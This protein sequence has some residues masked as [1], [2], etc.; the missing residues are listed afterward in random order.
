MSN[1][2]LVD[3]NFSA[4]PI[5]DYLVQSGH[6][7][8]VV[9][10]KPNDALAKSVNNYVNLDYTNIDR[11]L[12][13]VEDHNIDFLVP[14]CNDRSYLVCAELNS[15]GNFPGI[16]KLETAHTINNKEMFRAFC[17]GEGL[18]TPKVLNESEIG[19]KWP[20]IVKPVDAYSGRGVTVIHHEDNERLKG[21]LEL[22]ASV[23]VSGK[24]IVESYVEGQLYSHSAFIKN[25]K[26]VWDQVV[27]EYG[28]VNPF[29]VDTSH[30]IYD[31]PTFY[32]E[33]LCNSVHKICKKLR[34][35]NGLVHTQFIFD[36][37]DLWLIEVTRRCPGDLYSSL[38]Q[39]STGL[40][41][42]ENYARPFLGTDYDF[43]R[44][45]E[46]GLIMRHTVSHCAEYGFTGLSFRRGVLI[47]NL[48]PLCSNGD[49]MAAGPRGRAAII[50]AEERSE[51]DL[52]S[53]IETTLRRDLYTI[54]E[55]GI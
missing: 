49:Q 20:V 32:R 44:I 34:L 22:A 24:Y 28:T 3:T 21:A 14:G 5:Y 40:N 18:P 55:T 39:Y 1:V 30:V 38:I 50:F 10:A 23:S 51:S 11:M 12:R 8:T 17:A 52:N 7:V 6:E 37:N 53:L 46:G 31:F 9:G 29:A 13:L 15:H 45:D 36:G 33:Q 47:R 35:R 16:D 43:N 2:L 48:I 41:Y 25:Q 27:V 19:V 54:N 42:A 26:I 4:R